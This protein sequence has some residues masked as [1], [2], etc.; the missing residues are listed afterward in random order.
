MKYEPVI[1]VAKPA[2]S[3]HVGPT[4]EELNLEKMRDENKK[5]SQKK[6]ADANKNAFVPAVLQRPDNL[7]AVRSEVMAIRDKEL[8]FEGI[9]ANPIPKFEK[10]NVGDHSR[11]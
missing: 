6:L 1:Y 9:K 8:R 3:A 7:E 10:S 5:N 4:I 11:L 2:P